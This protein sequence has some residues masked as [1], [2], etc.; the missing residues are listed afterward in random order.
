MIETI[1]NSQQILNN[2]L[3][4]KWNESVFRA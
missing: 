3:K 1:I 2:L 4:L